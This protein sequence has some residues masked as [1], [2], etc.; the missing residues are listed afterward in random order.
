MIEKTTPPFL[1][2]FRKCHTQKVIQ[3]NKRIMKTPTVRS[4]PHG[5]DECLWLAQRLCFNRHVSTPQST[6][7]A[8]YIAYAMY[9]TTQ[10]KQRIFSQA[11][12]I[13]YGSTVRVL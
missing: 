8:T 5:L 7:V 4:H 13:C 10:G 6:M 2:K 3:N 11:K 9:I 1:S 12:L